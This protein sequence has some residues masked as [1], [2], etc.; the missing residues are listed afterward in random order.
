[1]HPSRCGRP[2]LPTS[3]R[4]AIRDRAERQRSASDI[5]GCAELAL[6]QKLPRVFKGCSARNSGAHGIRV[7]FRANR[8]N[9]VIPECP[10]M[11]A[12]MKAFVS[13][14]GD[15]LLPA[16]PM[17]DTQLRSDKG[18]KRLIV[19]EVPSWLQ[20]GATERMASKDEL[21]DIRRELRG[22]M[23]ARAT[24]L[25]PWRLPIVEG[26]RRQAD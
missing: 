4:A 6:S 14:A 17:P 22:V 24:A 12:V 1:M 13:V 10:K 23:F 2:H 5:A 18:I 15:G 20:C 21:A 7:R 26:L 25:I 9:A 3:H 19:E 11:E 16:P 8:R